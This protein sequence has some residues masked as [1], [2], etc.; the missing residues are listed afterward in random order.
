MVGADLDAQVTDRSE[1]LWVPANDRSSPSAAGSSGDQP[2]PGS[3]GHA[4]LR[5]SSQK[6][7]QRPLG[8]MLKYDAFKQPGLHRGAP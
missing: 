3:E 6:R 5:Q 4:A 1:R 2:R 8:R 7:E